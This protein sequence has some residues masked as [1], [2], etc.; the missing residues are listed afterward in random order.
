[1]ATENA[2]EALRQYTAESRQF[3][4][5]VSVPPTNDS[6]EVVRPFEIV[7]NIFRFY[8]PQAISE[9]GRFDAITEATRNAWSN[10]MR[11]IQQMKEAASELT[12]PSILSEH[13]RIMFRDESK[14]NTILVNP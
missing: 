7:L 4:N 6:E 2:M 13:L 11:M 3:W 5:R 12:D 8:Y 1:M 14:L 10:L 9:N